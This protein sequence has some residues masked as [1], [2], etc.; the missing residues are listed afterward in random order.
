MRQYTAS[1]RP[2]IG[3]RKKLFINIYNSQK[4]EFTNGKQDYMFR[5]KNV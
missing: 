3:F 2:E 5:T 4:N 1:K